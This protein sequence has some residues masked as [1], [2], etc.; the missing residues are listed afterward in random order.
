MTEHDAHMYDDHDDLSPDEFRK[1]FA[2]GIPADINPGPRPV[3][4]TEAWS[5]MRVTDGF[6]GGVSTVT[7]APHLTAS[8]ASVLV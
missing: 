6:G 3:L 2:A 7:P 1:A 4:V 5:G 8:R